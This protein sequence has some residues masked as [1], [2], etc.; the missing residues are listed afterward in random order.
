MSELDW[1]TPAG[2]AAAAGPLGL[3]GPGGKLA[4]PTRM[5]PVNALLDALPATMRAEI[6]RGVL[7][8]LTM[9]GRNLL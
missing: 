3:L 6:L 5:A 2:L 7:T 8:L 9:P 4:L 1:S